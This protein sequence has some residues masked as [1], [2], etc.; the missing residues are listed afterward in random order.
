MNIQRSSQQS[1]EIEPVLEAVIEC[2]IEAEG[3][4]L[5]YLARHYITAQACWET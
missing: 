5:L 4:S 1:F 2:L 3:H